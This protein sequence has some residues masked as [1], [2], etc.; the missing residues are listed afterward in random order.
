MN[1]DPV[2][3][4]IRNEQMRD[5]AP[6]PEEAE[7]QHREWLA[8]CGCRVEGCDVD[9]PDELSASMPHIPSCGVLQVPTDVEPEVYCEEHMRPARER[10]IEGR[11]NR[12]DTPSTKAIVF[13]E[14]ENF[15]YGD[16][17]DYPESRKGPGAESWQDVPP[18]HRPI[19]EV[20]IRCRCGDPI[21]RIVYD[22]GEEV[23]L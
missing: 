14:C 1:R 22:D 6:S 16:Y 20:P 4:N 8:K 10:W 21:D 2:A 12:L 19:P 7:R 18:S 9:D 17:P 15:D 11:L 5:A 3:R 23:D 13:Y